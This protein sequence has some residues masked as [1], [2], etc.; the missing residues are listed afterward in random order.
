RK[1]MSKQSSK[2][3]SSKKNN[4]QT[5]QMIKNIIYLLLVTVMLSACSTTKYLPPGEKLYTGHKVKVEGKD[6]KNKEAKALTED[7]KGLLRPKPNSSI[8]G[9]RV[10]LW[11]YYKTY[12]TK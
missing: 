9:L 12:T 10:K 1:R 11:I 8:L 4:L 6:M 7:L 2:W 5:K 3:N